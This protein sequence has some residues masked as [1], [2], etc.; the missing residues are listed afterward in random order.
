M[1][2][3]ASRLPPRDAR[4]LFRDWD[5]DNDGLVSFDELKRKLVQ[6][7]PNISEEELVLIFASIDRD[8]SGFIDIDE[9]LEWLYS[10][11]KHAKQVCAS[12]D[13]SGAA[14][15]EECA[16]PPTAARARNFAE[17][18]PLPVKEE[19]DNRGA[20]HQR[21]SM[22]AISVPPFGGEIE[23]LDEPAIFMVSPGERRRREN[24]KRNNRRAVPEAPEEERNSDSSEDDREEALRDGVQRRV[25]EQVKVLC[26]KQLARKQGIRSGE[27]ACSLEG[28]EEV[29]AEAGRFQERYCDTVDV[30]ERNVTL[31]APKRAHTITISELEERKLSADP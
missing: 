10:E 7:D 30:L 16:E 26:L 5:L 21:D 8:K 18:C 12:L 13:G 24:Q 2:F 31:T 28:R 19:Q 9:F 15:G 4:Q 3:A 25:A 27:N 6:E 20:T 17:S 14:T 23:Q 22:K 1:G 29:R 11:E